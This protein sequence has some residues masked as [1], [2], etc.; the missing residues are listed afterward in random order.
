MIVW[1][2]TPTSAI[3]YD[4]TP[5]GLEENFVV[6]VGWTD[7]MEGEE[8]VLKLGLTYHGFILSWSEG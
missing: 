5:W 2:I 1:E 6:I 3:D 7:F 4:F 8:V